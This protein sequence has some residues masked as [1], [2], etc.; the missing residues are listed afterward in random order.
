V[1]KTL[2]SK[3]KAIKYIYQPQVG[4]LHHLGVRRLYDIPRR[5]ITSPKIIILAARRGVGASIMAE[6]LQIPIGKLMNSSDATDV[7]NFKG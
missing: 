4:Y 2:V 3:E 1:V 7:L 5:L 6:I